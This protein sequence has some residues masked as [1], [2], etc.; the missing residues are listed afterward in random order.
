MP[1]PIRYNFI[2]HFNLTAEKAYKWS[3]DFSPIDPAIM[4]EKNQKREVTK[5]TDFT[6][7]LKETFHTNNGDIIKEK[8]VQLYPDKLTWVSTHLSGPNKH[9]QFIYEIS[10]KK[11]DSSQL[12]F[13][14][15]HL[16]YRDHMTEKE[17]ET[18]ASDLCRYD[19][20]VWKLLAKAME[21]EINY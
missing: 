3:T 21:K 19:S 13:T 20:N 17:V 12:N 6:I 7:L 18:L 5:S 8:L 2:Q 16:E 10:S 4:N 14:A 1:Y 9:S 15:L 11:E